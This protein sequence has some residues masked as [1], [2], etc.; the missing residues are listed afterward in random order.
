MHSWFIYLCPSAGWEWTTGTVSAT[1]SRSTTSRG[2]V[3]RGDLLS[4]KVDPFSV[5][6]ECSAVPETVPFLS[7]VDEWICV[8]LLL[9]ARGSSFSFRTSSELV[10]KFAFPP[11]CRAFLWS[12]AEPLARWAMKT[13]V[14]NGSSGQPFATL[15]C[16]QHARHTHTHTEALTFLSRDFREWR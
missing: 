10:P 5:C 7:S 6:W 3:H 2:D 9:A 15:K 8:R 16:Y 1:S 11:L 13:P 4:G 12:K 14:K